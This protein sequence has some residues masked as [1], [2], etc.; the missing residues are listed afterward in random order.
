M[1]MTRILRLILSLAI[2]LAIGAIAGMF[3]ADAIP[4]WYASLNQPAINPPN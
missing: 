1:K 2:P 4:G 3:T